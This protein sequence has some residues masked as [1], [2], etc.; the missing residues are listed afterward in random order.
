MLQFFSKASSG[1]S[2]CSHNELE[3]SCGG[4]LEQCFLYVLLHNL[5]K[6]TFFFLKNVCIDFVGCQTVQRVV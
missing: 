6:L 3:Y 1:F 4:E 5:K 2:A